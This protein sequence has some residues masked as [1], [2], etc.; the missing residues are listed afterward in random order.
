MSCEQIIKHYANE[1]NKNSC[2]LLLRKWAVVKELVS[3]LQI[4]HNVTIFFQRQK[5]TLSDVF[6]R[7]LGMQL[8]LEAYSKR[9]TKKT[10]LAN[11][12][13]E[14][15]KKRKDKIFNNPLMACALYLDPRFQSEILKS[16]VKVNEAK[17]TMLKI[18]RR[19]IALRASDTNQLV[20]AEEI[21]S[22]NESNFEFDELLALEKHL[23]RD[24]QSNEQQNNVASSQN[25]SEDIETIIDTYQPDSIPLTSS[26]LSYWEDMKEK[27]RQLYDIASVVF[28]VPP[29]EVKI[30]RDFSHLD[31]VFTKRRGN[32]CHNRLEDIFVIHLNKDLFEV[33][34]QQEISDL[35]EEMTSETNRA[36]KSLQM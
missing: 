7:W 10:V 25:Y 18:W 32:L 21:N 33:V 14:Q 16:P 29:T 8:H 12:L 34:T 4:M 13:L 36:K 3:V 30:E 2:Q 27:E 1:E 31:C 17:A 28:S 20:Q 24:R 22:S 5:L 15:T 26:I 35:Y 9:S 6:G 19:L 11:H 23:Q